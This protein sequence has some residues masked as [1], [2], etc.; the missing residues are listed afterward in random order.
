M[1]ECAYHVAPP[2]RRMPAVKWRVHVD[3]AGGTLFLQRCKLVNYVANSEVNDPTTHE[4]VEH[5]LLFA[6]YSVFTVTNGS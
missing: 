4:P 3:P 1:S 5:E 2:S 6:A